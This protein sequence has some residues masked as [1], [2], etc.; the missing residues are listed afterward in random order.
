MNTAVRS[1]KEGWTWNLAC[2]HRRDVEVQQCSWP[3]LYLLERKPVAIVR[4]GVRTPTVIRSP[5][6]PAPADLFRPKGLGISEWNIKGLTLRPHFILTQRKRWSRWIYSHSDYL[7]HARV[8]DVT[9]RS[10]KDECSGP[11]PHAA[12]LRWCAR[13]ILLEFPNLNFVN[14]A[15][16][17]VM[18]SGGHGPFHKHCSLTVHCL[19]Y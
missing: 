15:L 6:L 9:G 2:R 8:R 5:D 7:L 1:R 4:L 11:P 12:M 13:A 17:C 19:L 10:V 3:R 18:L 14:E 16:F